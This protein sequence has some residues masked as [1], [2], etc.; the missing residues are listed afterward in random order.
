MD[1]PTS[2]GAVSATALMGPY[3][4]TSPSAAVMG[5]PEAASYLNLSSASLAKM[6]CMG[7]GPVFIR[8]GRKIGYQRPDLDDWLAARRTINTSDAAA[9]LP[10]KL[11]I[12]A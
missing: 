1:K 6:R 10:A 4:P 5:T 2:A 7:G 3:V 8:L 11:T 9:R 12:A